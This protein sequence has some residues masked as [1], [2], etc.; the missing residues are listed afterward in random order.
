MKGIFQSDDTLN[1]VA[2]FEGTGFVFAPFNLD[3]NAVVIKPGDICSTLY[4]M[5]EKREQPEKFPPDQDKAVHLKLVEKG[6]A[7][8]EKG[9]LKKVVLSR[10]IEVKLSR[11]PAETFQ[12]LLDSYRNTFCYLFFHPKVGVWCGATPETLVRIQNQK[13]STMSLA[14]TLPYKHGLKPKWGSKEI[15]EQEMVSSYINERLSG[16]MEEL[17]MGNAQSVKAGN[18][19]HLK[20]EI[21]GKLFSTA[22]IRDIIAALHPT[23]AVCG[24]PMEESKDFIQSN[25]NYQRTYYTGFLGELNMGDSNETHLF[26]NLRCVEFAGEKA[27]IFVGGGIT[28]ASNPESEWTE[29]QNKSMTMLDMI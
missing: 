25:E 28:A 20:S 22:K 13:L 1:T 18:L 5:E 16:S 17:H 19:W 8:I 3:D 11:S 7:A 6:I 27:A 23:P 12:N 24:I 9:T 26:V 2:D 15:E 21:K 14:A 10:K 29:T 4:S